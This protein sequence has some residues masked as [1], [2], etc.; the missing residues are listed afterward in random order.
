[1]SALI[2]QLILVLLK[3]SINPQF[4]QVNASLLPECFH[5]VFVLFMLLF[6]ASCAFG[7]PPSFLPPASLQSI[8]H[9]M[10]PLSRISEAVIPCQP[11]DSTPFMLF[12]TELNVFG[13]CFYPECLIVSQVHTNLVW[14]AHWESDL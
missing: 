4:Y 3:H 2:L 8:S 10:F 1:M 12:N 6:T 5:S 7:F 9:C 14:M 11:C 13:G